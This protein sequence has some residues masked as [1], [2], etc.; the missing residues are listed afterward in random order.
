MSADLFV[1]HIQTTYLIKFINT[2]KRYQIYLGLPFTLYMAL[3]AIMV[4]DITPCA[5]TLNYLSLLNA[6]KKKEEKK[7]LKAM[8]DVRW[9][10]AVTS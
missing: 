10:E 3:E 1:H 6:K 7:N 9:E 2:P 5:I 4:V 8:S